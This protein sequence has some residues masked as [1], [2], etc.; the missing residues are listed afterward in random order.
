MK[1]GS[2]IFDKGELIGGEFIVD[3]STIANT[4]MTGRFQSK[5]EKHLKSND[6][7]NVLAYPKHPNWF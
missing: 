2:L 1:E 4:D 7:F 5:L 3:M 6:F